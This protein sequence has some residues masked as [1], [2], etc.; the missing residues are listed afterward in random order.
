VREPKTWCLRLHSRI[1][2]GISLARYRRV[3]RNAAALDIFASRAISQRNVSI[4]W[5]NS[6]QDTGSHI[7][8]LTNIFSSLR[9]RTVI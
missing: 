7:D 2:A 9:L 5:H 3:A 4:H 8:N 6:V 1:C